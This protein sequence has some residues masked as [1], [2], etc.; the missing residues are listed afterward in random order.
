MDEFLK[1]R[2]IEMETYAIINYFKLLRQAEVA[3]VDTYDSRYLPEETFGLIG[4]ENSFNRLLLDYEEG[5]ID[6]F[7][8]SIGSL[9]EKLEINIEYIKGINF[10]KS[11]SIKK[12]ISDFELIK[13]FY[14]EV[15][16][17]NG[18]QNE[19][20]IYDL[21]TLP[22]PNILAVLWTLYM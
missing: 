5:N 16:S 13:K 15:Y 7:S 17:V 1:D 3:E 8:D 14:S 21:V 20:A 10:S 19:S 22:L 18:N 4:G 2:Q 9:F 11:V 12:A 6:V